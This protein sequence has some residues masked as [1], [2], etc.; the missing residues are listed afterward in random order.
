MF[1]PET[2][3][4]LFPGADEFSVVMVGKLVSITF[5]GDADVFIARWGPLVPLPAPALSEGWYFAYAPPD[6]FLIT[7]LADGSLGFGLHRSFTAL[8]LNKVHRLVAVSS[9]EANAISCYTNGR[10]GEYVGTSPSFL[11]AATPDAYGVLGMTVTGGGGILD[12]G[13]LTWEVCDIAVIDRAFTAR[14][15]ADL[16]ELITATGHLPEYAWVEH[17]QAERLCGHPMVWDAGGQNAGRG[18]LAVEEAP[19]LGSVLI[20]PASWGGT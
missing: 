3:T 16:D 13:V 2:P 9:V 15:V 14:E 6:A 18:W 19:I 10:I 5:I 1:L 17:Y 20:E 12:A 7:T 4:R 8:D 11:P